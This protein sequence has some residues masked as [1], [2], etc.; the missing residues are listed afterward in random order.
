MQCAAS[1]KT[2]YWNEMHAKRPTIKQCATCARQRQSK[3]ASRRKIPRIPKRR[4]NPMRG[5]QST[6]ST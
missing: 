4:S 1:V 6:T 5:W 2:S 3:L